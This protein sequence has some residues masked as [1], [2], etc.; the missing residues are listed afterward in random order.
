VELCGHFSR[1]YPVP[2]EQEHPEAHAPQIKVR[3]HDSGRVDTVVRIAA[4]LGILAIGAVGWYA[5]DVYRSRQPRAQLQDAAP[6]PVSSPAQAIPAEALPAPLTQMQ[7]LA[8]EA[9]NETAGVAA[10]ESNASSAST[11]NSTDILP[12]AP[13]KPIEGKPAVE[14]PATP[15][16]AAVSGKPDTSE[17]P[18]PGPA[19]AGRVRTLRISATSA[20]WLQARPDGK[21]VDYF[22]RKGESTAITFSTSLTIKFGNAGGVGLELDGQPYPF[23]AALGEVKTLVLE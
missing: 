3:M 19:A 17:K 20:S 15:E 16:M 23:E 13:E 9:R 5:F 18:D 1:E 2:T 6:A 7:E 22:L 21:V 12:L 10:E 4:I 14:K 11:G 8:A